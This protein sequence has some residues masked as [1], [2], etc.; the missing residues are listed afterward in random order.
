MGLR[1]TSWESE[2]SPT[3]GSIGTLSAAPT[4][5]RSAPICRQRW[6]EKINE[7]S[8]DQAGATMRHTWRQGTKV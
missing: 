1:G 2:W 8:E 7:G 3:T 4:E 5:E 6:H